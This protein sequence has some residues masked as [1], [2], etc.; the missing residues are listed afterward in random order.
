MH[1]LAKLVHYIIRNIGDIIDRTFADRLKP[2][3]QPIGRRPDL[4]IFDDACRE[5][6]TEIR[7]FDRDKFGAWAQ[8]Q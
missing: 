2:L 7:I 8:N 4:H 1:R 5:A 6:M 3:N